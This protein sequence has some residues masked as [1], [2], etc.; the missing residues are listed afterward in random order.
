M[1][2]WGTV[3]HMEWHGVEHSLP[4]L[5]K[6]SHRNPYTGSTNVTLDP[7]FWGNFTLQ[8]LIKLFARKP[9]RRCRM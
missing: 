8:T 5:E 1:T 3:V 2:M 4:G 7:C 6:K 9:F